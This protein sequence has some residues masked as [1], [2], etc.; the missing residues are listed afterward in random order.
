MATV[1]ELERG[2]TLHLLTESDVAPKEGVYV[3]ASSWTPSS[4]YYRIWF[5]NGWYPQT[6]YTVKAAYRE[7]ETLRKLRTDQNLG[8]LIMISILI[9]FA[10]VL[11]FI[12]KE[13]LK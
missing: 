2:M 13:V 7:L 3:M 5:K 4:I 9:F 1:I 11:A 12:L 6:F 8:A 10:G